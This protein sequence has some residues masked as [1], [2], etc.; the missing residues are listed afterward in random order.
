VS[1][2][3][4]HL[5]SWTPG[6]QT[7]L[8][9]GT[10][11]L[12]VLLL[13]GVGLFQYVA[14][15]AS[16]L[17]HLSDSL[18]RQA[19]YAIAGRGR[20]PSASTD[21]AALA[22]DASSPDVRAAVVSNG[23]DLLALGPA[24]PGNMVWIP[25]GAASIE[26]A[27]ATHA[28]PDYWLLGSGRDSVLVIA[29]PLQPDAGT[30]ED[31]VLEG[32]LQPTDAVLR[33]DLV[34]YAAGSALA[35]LLGAVVSVFMTRRALKRLH[36]V[37][38][39]A[40]AI[41]DGDL[42]R[43]ASIAGSDEVAALGA[44]F[45]DMVGKLQAEM[46]RQQTSEA[47]MRRFLADAS[48]EL[49]TPVALIRG[50]LD[51][52]RRGAAAD[53]ADRAL[54]LDDMHRAAVRMSRLVDDLLA[55]ARV[56][57]GE[58]PQVADLDVRSVLEEAARSGRQ[59]ARG[60]RIGVAVPTPIRVAADPDALSR[61]LQNLV[62]NAIKYAPAPS[63]ITLVAHAGATGTVQIEVVDEGPGIPP[64]DRV[65]IFDRFYRGQQQ[66]STSDGTGL[67]LAI[68]TALIESQGGT[69]T[70]RSKPGKGSTFVVTLPSP[71][72]PDG[73]RTGARFEPFEAE[74]K[75]LASGRP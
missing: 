31:L 71:E 8:V 58:R 17:Q 42:G 26:R 18:H 19:H 61:A 66:A 60:R 53:P 57:Q 35:V 68:S 23:T 74:A 25:P 65:R 55:L 14:L 10:L 52:L 15:R 56:E 11:G 69:L 12:V 40:A 20:P 49:R 44:V 34:I 72:S 67:G 3:R 16:L 21:P 29:V 75:S 24:G 32:S 27:T 38:V 43:R 9:A 28:V 64:E 41:A 6:L 4:R 48:H 70:V 54:S 50:N 33:G 22:R 62:D 13:I 1:L 73:A 7:R 5:P 37:A 51:I 30:S 59:I 46:S 63:P 36:R 2:P 47:A 45:D 39:T